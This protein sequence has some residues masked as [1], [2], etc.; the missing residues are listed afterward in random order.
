MKGIILA[1]GCGTRLNPLTSALNKHLLPVYDKPMIFYPLST[2][3]S[4]DI[5]DI[6]V[7]TTPQDLHIFQRL[8]DDG[9]KW[10]I[11]ITY[12]VQS[13]PTTGI[14]EALIIAERFL[15]GEP[16]T[17]ILGDNIFYGEGVSEALKLRTTMHDLNLT[18][19]VKKGATV[20]AYQVKDPRR[21]GVVEMDAGGT[22]VSIE[23][24]PEDPKTNYAVTGLYCYDGRAS[25]LAK[26]IR[27]SDRGQLEI[28]DLNKIYLDEGT[29]SVVEFSRGVAW[30]DTGTFNSLND[31]SNFIKAIQDRQGYIIAD[32]TEIA[33]NKG[34]I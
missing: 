29:L 7:I 25:E 12:E 6:M 18:D 34:W 16:C 20:F 19:K 23:E 17:L 8:L 11:S 9:S 2:L 31:A 13:N 10:G 5:Q 21:Y 4:A 15:N 1:G 26:K 22:A 24:K 32:L 30:L 14:A 28:T 27:P 3:M 33:I